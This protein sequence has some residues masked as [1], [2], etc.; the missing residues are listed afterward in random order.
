MPPLCPA[1][2]YP[3]CVIDPAM[4]DPSRNDG[5]KLLRKLRPIWRSVARGVNAHLLDRDSPGSLADM[6]APGL[7]GKALILPALLE[8]AADVKPTARLVAPSTGMLSP[9]TMDEL[10]SNEE[11]TGV[12]PV[13]G[14]RRCAVL[15]WPEHMRPQPKIVIVFDKADFASDAKHNAEMEIYH[16]DRTLDIQL[17]AFDGTRKRIKLVVQDV[18]M[19]ERAFDTTELVDPIERALVPKLPAELPASIMEEIADF[20]QT[21]LRAHVLTAATRPAGEK[22]SRFLSFSKIS[23]GT[24]GRDAASKRV[25]VRATLHPS[26]AECICCVHSLKPVELQHPGC[27][28]ASSKVEFTM[29]MCGAKLVKPSRLMEFGICPLH[30]GA[31]PRV[32]M[33][34]DLCCHGTTCQV[35]CAHFTDKR[36]FKPGLWIRNIPL[37]KANVL[38][39]Q[40][41]IQAAVRCSETVGPMI[42]KRKREEIKEVCDAHS[43]TLSTHLEQVNRFKSC[44]E[45]VYGADDLLRMDQKAA[46]LLRERKVCQYRRPSTKELVLAAPKE[47]EDG[48]LGGLAPL[49]RPDS[50]LNDHHLWMFKAPQRY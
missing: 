34:P 28:F 18:R 6:L 37:D 22:S 46:D 13:Q 45:K 43:Q 8:S 14:D 30:Q 24:T 9:E 35:S 50:E 27:K 19:I 26:A 21:I 25:V 15:G 38:H 47:E 33:F 44:R 32:T 48:S 23:V 2:A 16:S 20:W 7:L 49:T 29:S 11:R 39:V 42:G 5:E 12:I 10:M 41:L 3:L 1:I 4:D 31:T 40:A 36:E 17:V